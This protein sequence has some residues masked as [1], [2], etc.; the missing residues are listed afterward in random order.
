MLEE[1][2]EIL[3]ER[4]VRKLFVNTSDLTDPQRGQIYKDAIKTYETLGF[5]L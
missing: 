2:L 4:G 1:L 3:K 5:R